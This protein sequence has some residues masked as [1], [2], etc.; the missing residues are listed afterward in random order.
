MHVFFMS[1]KLEHTCIKKFLKAYM[2]KIKKKCLQFHSDP[3]KC[4]LPKLYLKYVIY[5]LQIRIKQ[6]VLLTISQLLS[7]KVI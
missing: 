1:W 4:T 6:L 5:E 2:L 3:F 7:R